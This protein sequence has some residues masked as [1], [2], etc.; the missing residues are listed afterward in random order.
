MAGIGSVGDLFQGAFTGGA[1]P[2]SPGFSGSSSASTGPTVSGGGT[3]N[4]GQVGASTGS[5][6][7]FL[8]L[9]AAGIAIAFFSR[10]RKGRK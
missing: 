9:G 4:F 1:G 8:I 2:G 10:N 6:T 7:L 3:V 5:N